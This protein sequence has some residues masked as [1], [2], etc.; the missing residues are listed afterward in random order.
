MIAGMEDPY[1]PFDPNV[2]V[3]RG[4]LPVFFQETPEQDAVALVTHCNLDEQTV[5]LCIFPPLGVPYV[6]LGV[7]FGTDVGQWHW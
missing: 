2:G 6:R 4:E 1:D 3:G 5:N 7:R